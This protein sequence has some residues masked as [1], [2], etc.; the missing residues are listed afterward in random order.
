M[1]TVLGLELFVVSLKWRQAIV[2]FCYAEEVTYG[3]DPG[4]GKHRPRS[5]PC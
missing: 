2:L 4:A 3:R 5:V 1:L